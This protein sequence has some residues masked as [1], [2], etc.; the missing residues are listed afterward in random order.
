MKVSMQYIGRSRLKRSG[1]GQRI[2]DLAPNLTRDYVAFDASLIDPIRFRE[3]I[4]S[5][6][7]IVINDLTFKPRDKSAY[8]RWKAHQHQAEQAIRNEARE[9]ARSELATASVATPSTELKRRYQTS[10]SRYWKARRRLNQ[11][12][13]THNDQLWRNLMPYDPV[14]TVAD[15]VVF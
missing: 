10:L 15:D 4:S 6:H 9:R 8:K 11:H 3:A 2:L 14:I 5:L 7:D 1:S 12:L 13:K